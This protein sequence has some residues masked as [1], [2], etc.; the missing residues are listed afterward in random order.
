MGRAGN[1]ISAFDPEVTPPDLFATNCWRLGDISTEKDSD[2]VLRRT[3]SFNLKWHPAFKSVARQFKINLENARI[4]PDKILLP[5]P[6]DK[7]VTVALDR[8]GNFDLTDFVGDKIP[9]VGNAAT[10][11]SNASGTWASSWPRGI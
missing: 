11:H 7:D 2:G 6:D 9:R 5:Q 4:E 1:V 3:K 8:D 10:N